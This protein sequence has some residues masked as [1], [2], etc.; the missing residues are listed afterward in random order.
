MTGTEQ[1]NQANTWN[2]TGGRCSHTKRLACFCVIR[3]EVSFPPD[4]VCG[5][6]GL[7]LVLWGTFQIASA[8]RVA[9]G[10]FTI[11]RCMAPRDWH[12][13]IR[14]TTFHR[15]VACSFHSRFLF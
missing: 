11:E 2:A 7:P 15:Q 4:S 5:E 9:L 14:G 12:G 10:G 13:T 6:R 3:I 8:G 1:S